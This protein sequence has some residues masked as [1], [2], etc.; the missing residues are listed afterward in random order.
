ML[1]F[2]H[3]S[4]HEWK[5]KFAV[6]PLTGRQITKIISLLSA[7]AIETNSNKIENH[8]KQEIYFFKECYKGHKQQARRT[9]ALLDGVM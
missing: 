4:D 1:Y 7:C 6:L 3:K 8:F 2:E 9:N 5:D